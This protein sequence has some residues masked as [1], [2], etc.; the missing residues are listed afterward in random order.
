MNPFQ[1]TERL[2]GTVSEYLTWDHRRLETIFAEVVQMVD[3]G[4]I[5]R[6]DHTYAPFHEGMLRHIR[7]EEEILW[8]LFEQRS[9]IGKGMGPTTVMNHEHASMKEAMQLMR[10]ALDRG[11]GAEFH[12]ARD[13]LEQ[14]LEPHSAKEERV[15]YP[16]I[17]RLIDRAEREELL[18]RVQR[19]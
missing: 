16:A 7:I 19:A 1:E 18:Q 17:E 12:D 11:K 14:I 9:G 15:L 3:D 4:E 8:P 2:F 13:M 5:E 10:D 6:A